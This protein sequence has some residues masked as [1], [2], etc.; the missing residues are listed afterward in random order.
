MRKKL[1]K[2]TALALTLC[3]TLGSTGVFAAN[4][5]F[6]FDFT[7]KDQKK[8]TADY[9]KEDNE[10]NAY[11]TLKDTNYSNFISGDVF[12]CRVRKASG[13]AAVTNYTTIKK[14]GKYKL[15]YTAKGYKNTKYHL[16]GQIDSS[17]DYSVLKVEGVWLP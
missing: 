14:I 15:P 10:Q 13:N 9:A 17:G 11:V 1:G 7:A 4:Q 3:M 2:V 8:Q 12:G 6:K 5:S 16:V